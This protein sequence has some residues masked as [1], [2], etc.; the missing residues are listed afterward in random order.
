MGGADMNAADEDGFTCLHHACRRGN[1]KMVEIL[2]QHGANPEIRDKDGKPPSYVARVFKHTQ[3]VN[4][5]P[6]EENPYSW[7][8][9]VVEEITK[10]ELI[11]NNNILFAAERKKKPGKKKKKK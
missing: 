10:S 8:S 5:L 3:I 2:L 4:M 11:V 9:W 7:Q 1:V 6:K